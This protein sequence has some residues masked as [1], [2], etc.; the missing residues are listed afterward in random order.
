MVHVHQVLVHECVMA[1][2]CLTEPPRLVAGVGDRAEVGD[3][4]LL[5]QIGLAR[6]DKHESAGLLAG[7]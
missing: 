4:A 2:H 5:G 6:E 7:V 1:A 3:G